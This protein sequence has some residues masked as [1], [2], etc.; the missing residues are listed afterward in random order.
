M[1][2]LAPPERPLAPF[3]RACLVIGALA[4]LLSLIGAFLDPGRF[5]QSYLVAWLYILGIALGATTLLALHMLVGGIWGLLLRPW[6][7]ALGRALPLTALLGL[8]LLF[9]LGMLFPWLQ[10]PPS[11]PASLH[12]AGYLNLPFFLLRQA[13]Y[14][15]VWLGLSRRLIHEVQAIDREP[16][17]ERAY[18]LQKLGAAWLVAYL[19]TASFAGIDWVVSLER[20]WNSSIFGFVWMA[21]QLLLGLAVAVAGFC[22]L[23]PRTAL[24]RV[25]HVHLRLN[26]MGNLLLTGVMTWA[27]VAFSQFL[28]SWAGNLPEGIVWY[29]HR[30]AGSWLALTWFLAI[31]QFAVPFSALLFRGIKRRPL[32][33]GLL[34]GLL[35]MTQLAYTYWLLL[36][37]FHPE[38]MQPHLLDGLAPLA[39]GGLFFAEATRQLRRRDSLLPQD[40]RLTMEAPHGD[41]A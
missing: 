21:G 32:P 3:Q 5:F 1:I 29:V 19:V 35:V 8:P 31:F 15:V 7:E 28:I 18:R 6:L 27:Y 9:G 17:R 12:Q 38:G 20:G 10:S 40:A 14:L 13:V 36:P 33:L 2:R 39:L 16:S 4:L 30:S 37:S 25:H 24:R 22:W 23:L 41:P 11:E 26:D 34:A